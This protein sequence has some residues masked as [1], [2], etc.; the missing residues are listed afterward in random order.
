[1]LYVLFQYIYLIKDFLL[2]WVTFISNTPLPPEVQVSRNSIT[3]IN[4]LQAVDQ[5]LYYTCWSWT[6]TDIP[7]RALG[8]H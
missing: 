7:Q 5:K 4:K 1:M 6:K 2:N 3:L 8:T